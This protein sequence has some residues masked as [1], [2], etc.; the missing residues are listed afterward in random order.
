MDH[1]FPILSWIGINVGGVFAP[2]LVA[3]AFFYY[4][5]KRPPVA[6]NEFYGRG[7]LGLISLL[8]S[9][10]VIVDVLKSD[11]SGLLVRIMA[12]SIAIF[13]LFAGGQWATALCIDK[14]GQIVDW[15]RLWRDSKVL[16]WAVFAIGIV[17]EI[18]L[19]RLA[20]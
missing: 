8:L 3:R 19:E 12:W 6:L 13:G 15:K 11:Q 2:V 7:E 16:A 4:S 9:L 14:A 1:W 17:T 10:T 18:L 20:A 5:L